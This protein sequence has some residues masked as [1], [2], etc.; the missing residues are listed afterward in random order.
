MSKHYKLLEVCLEYIHHA[1]NPPEEIIIVYDNFDNKKY[2]DNN[3]SD[4]LLK[5]KN[6]KEVFAKDRLVCVGAREKG[7]VVSTHDV[8]SFIDADDFCHPQRFDML[9]YCFSD[10]NIL[11]INHSYISKEFYDLSD[12]VYKNDMFELIDDI[13]SI[14][15]VKCD[16]KLYDRYF[17]NG[18]EGCLSYP[19]GGTGIKCCHDGHSSVR[20]KVFDKVKF[21]KHK[22]ERKLKIKN[23]PFGGD[24]EF[25][26]DVLYTYNQSLLIDAKLSTHNR[27][28]L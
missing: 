10:E 5:Y 23:Y 27:F 25:C 11:H 26:M 28:K 14:R 9:R 20:R 16:E 3:L 15:T 1:N 18:Y 22:E 7:V 19:Y 13:E 24:Y 2:K 17:K 6:I 4:K 8:I 21:K 12:Y